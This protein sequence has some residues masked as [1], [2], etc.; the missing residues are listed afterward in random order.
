MKW[1]DIPD[2]QS[3]ARHISNF[4]LALLLACIVLCFPSCKNLFKQADLEDFVQTG[5]TNVLLRSETFSAGSGSF[6]RIPSGET[7]TCD[8]VIVNPKSF[9]VSYTLSWSVDDSLFTTE[10]SASPS[11][12]DA[13]N[14]SFDFI[15]DPSLAEHKKITFR[16]GKYV[17][18]I[19]KRYDPETFSVVC[20]SP[21]DKADRVTAI[22]NPSDQKSVLAV[23]LPTGTANDDLSKL[24]I[25]WAKEGG[26]SS[27]GTY[28]LSSLKTAP[29]SN[30]FSGTYD[31][32]FQPDD[33][34]AGY[35]YDYSVVVVDEAGQVSDSSS[36]SS[37]ANFFPVNY[38]GNGNTSGSPPASGSYRLNKAA[39]VAGPGDL[40]RTDYVFD[41]WNTAADGSGD[42]YEEG[43]S[44]SMPAREIIL[45]AQWYTTGLAVSFDLGIQALVFNRTEVTLTKGSTLTATTTNTALAALTDWTWYIDGAAIAGQTSSTLNY[46]TTALSI[47]SHTISAVVTDNSYGLS[48]SGHFTLTIAE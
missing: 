34:D 2:R 8:L 16:L 40:A 41:K 31:C 39:T 9:K 13:T 44:F 1:I 27:S 42:D 21:P 43:D 38:D 32:Y 25:T 7:V 4:R 30:P 18:S 45:Y 6:D 24:K 23:L 22:V 3:V 33:T 37:T 15:L 48:Y 5:L 19:N 29:S 14:L 12:K 35:G 17:A 36:C 28:S 47:G 11:P 26:S 46:G 20:D 10:P